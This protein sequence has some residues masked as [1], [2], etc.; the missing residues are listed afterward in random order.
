MMPRLTERERQVLKWISIGKTNWEIGKIL[1]IS[2]FTVK[3][4]VQNLLKKLSVTNRT[5]AVTKAIARGLL[6]AVEHKE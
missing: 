5:Q 1:G 3:N 4:H 2:E 6:D